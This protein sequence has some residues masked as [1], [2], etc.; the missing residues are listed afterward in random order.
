M[1]ARLFIAALITVFAMVVAL[2]AVVS[3][4]EYG[5]PTDFIGVIVL[6]AAW[7]IAGGVIVRARRRRIGAGPRSA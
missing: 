5:S 6:I 7:L 1:V 2:T 4:T 3:M